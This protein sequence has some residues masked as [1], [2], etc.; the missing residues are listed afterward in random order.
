MASGPN[1]NPF[2][3]QHYELACHGE[4]SCAQVRDILNRFKA[5]GLDVS[6]QELTNEEH[7]RIF[8]GIKQQFFPDRP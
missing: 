3:D 8:S 2:N 7:A 4:K 5:A 6:A 1:P